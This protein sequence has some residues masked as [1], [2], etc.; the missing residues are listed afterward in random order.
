MKINSINNLT[1][2]SFNGKMKNRGSIRAALTAS[3]VGT[4]GTLIP[5]GFTMIDSKINK[6]LSPK[7]VRK[8]NTYADELIKSTGLDK[9]GVQIVDVSNYDGHLLDNSLP[10]WLR[11]V[12][13]PIQAAA[14]GKNAFFCL[15]D[16][17]NPANGEILYAKNSIL[18]NR[19]KAPL[20]I[21]HELGHAHNKNYSNLTDARSS[22]KTPLSLL[23]TATNTVAIFGRSYEPQAGTKL[24]VLQ[25]SSNFIRKNA[26]LFA[27]G[28]HIG[29]TVEELTANAKANKWAKGLDKNIAKKVKVS[30]LA[31]TFTYL[32]TPMVAGL[33]VHAAVKVKD[34]IMGKRK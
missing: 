23:N 7:E 17:I 24:N 15:E 6:S 32:T 19:E 29:N 22:L 11:E 1:Q 34:S 8:I 2:T 14:K 31:G 21:L 4:V 13:D 5:I 25:N 9:K 27:A 10:N 16:V 12:N 18:V 3:A 30:N 33:A 28:T 26:G 20:A